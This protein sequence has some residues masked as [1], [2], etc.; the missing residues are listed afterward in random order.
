MGPF[1]FHELEVFT[2]GIID[3]RMEG[4][5]P[6]KPPEDMLPTYVFRI[7]LHGHTERVGGVRLRVGYTDDT[8]LYYGHIGYD[9][10]PD[11]RGRHFAA[12]ACLL[13]KPVIVAHGLD[14]IWITCNPDNRASRRTCER[15]GCE[16]IEIVDVPPENPMYRRGERQKCRYRWI[17]YGGNTSGTPVAI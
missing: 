2:D 14:V 11:Y 3:V 10:V 12:R 9:V 17:V 16:F 1:Q 13:I 7:T 15:I 6:A 4:G 8:V 5:R